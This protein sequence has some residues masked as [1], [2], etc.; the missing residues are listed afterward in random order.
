MGVPSV[1]INETSASTVWGSGIEQIIKGFL[2]LNLRPYLERIESSLER[3]LVPATDWSSV[4]IEFDF[5]DLLKPSLSER[6][7]SYSAGINSGVLSPNE[8]R[9]EEGLPPKDGGDN[10]YLNGSL[11]LVAGGDSDGD[12]AQTFSD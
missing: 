11:T 12:A 5:D 7:V 4:D 6:L 9:A 10:I 8:A 1:L 3:H 2:K